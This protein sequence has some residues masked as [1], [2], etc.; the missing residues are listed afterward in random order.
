MKN[1]SILLLFI[2]IVFG[3]GSFIGINTAPGAWFAGLEKPFFNPPSWIFAPVWSILYVAIAIAGWRVLKV[4]SKLLLGI[5]ILQLVLNFSWSPIF[6]TL[7]RPDLALIVILIL[8]LTIL[9]FIRLCW[10]KD[11]IAA[12]LFIPYAAWVGF[13]SV[14]NAAIFY[15]NSGL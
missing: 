11:R 14:L 9:T 7:Q 3:G 5:W 10:S 4:A 1:I 2:A 6:F 13:A 15:L 8:F 12:G